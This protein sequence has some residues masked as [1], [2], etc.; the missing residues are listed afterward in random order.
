M[1]DYG[2]VIDGQTFTEWATELFEFEFCAECHGDVADHEPQI[3]LG[4]WFAQCKRP[5]GDEF[6]LHLE[7]SN[8]IRTD[9][10]ANSPEGSSYVRV[11]GPDGAEIAY[12]TFTEWQEDP[13]LVM[14]AFLGSAGSAP[15]QD[16][17]TTPTPKG[18]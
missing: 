9:S 2:L 1:S 5:Y 18:N 12:W 3:V 4:H 13:Q 6:I 7:N 17:P 14:G 15:D 11:C 10:F 8:T 16:Q